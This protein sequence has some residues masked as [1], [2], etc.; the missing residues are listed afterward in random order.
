MTYLDNNATT[1]VAPEV[2]EAMLPFLVENYGNPS[3]AHSLGV[4][5]KNAIATA[6]T[7]VAGLIGAKLSEIVFTGSCTE[8]NH[9]AIS[10]VLAGNTRRIVTTSVE[11]PSTLALLESLEADVVRVPVLASGALDVDAL[12]AAVT[13]DTA[14]ISVMWANNETGALFPVEAAA[15]IAHAH[16]ALF[17]TDAAQVIGRVAVDL[18]ATGIDL[19]SFSGHKIHAPKGVGVLYVRRGVTLRPL[20][21]GQQERRR[22]GGTE[23]VSGIVALGAAC[24]LAAVSQVTESARLERLRDRLEAGILRRVPGAYVNA[25]VVQRLPNTSNITFGGIVAEAL[26]ARLDRAG[27]AASSGSACTAGGDEPSHVLLA[28]GLSP[29]EARSTLRLSLGRFNTDA[30]IDYVID[31]L[32]ALAA[33]LRQPLAA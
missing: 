23:N 10:G 20:I 16:G 22:R 12:E 15:R 5:A 29:R 6:R 28:M 30:D 19:A 8:S 21:H 4:V 33:G 25:A 11:H 17:H 31:T 14:L 26:L 27:I 18:A 24:L 7:R 9:I 3:S 13:P 1:R 2:L 32:P